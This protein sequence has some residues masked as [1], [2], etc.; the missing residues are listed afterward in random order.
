[1]KINDY[2]RGQTLIGIVI[3]LIIVGVITGG[4]YYYLSKQ[5]PEVPEITEKPAE[6]EVVK[7]EEVFPP[8]E[9]EVSPKEKIAEKEP[10]QNQVLKNPPI[11]D[12][13]LE[14]GHKAPS[15]PRLIDTIIIHSS[16]DALGENP[17]SVDGVI[18]EYKL[19]KV[20]PHYLIDR[21][22]VIY[23]LVEDENIAYH[24]GKGKM[25]DGRT[26]INDFSIGIELINTKTGSPNEI[27]YQSLV[28]LVKYLQQKYIVPLINILGHNQIAPE[29]KTDPWNFDW[30]KFN[31]MLK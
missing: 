17:Y 21:R 7:P 13:I 25:P 10:K 3:T 31:E 6:E 19:Y 1:M 23:R 12:R 11:I 2:S 28:Q 20:A 4:L 5:I 14:W 8:P 15:T 30:Q 9:E 26:N 22:G 27:Q 29:R 16:Y 18:Y 24:A